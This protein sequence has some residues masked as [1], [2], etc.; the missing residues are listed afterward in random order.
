[1]ATVT[2]TDSRPWRQSHMAK[3]V[4]KIA[5]VFYELVAARVSRTDTW[6]AKCRSRFPWFVGIHAISDV[7]ARKM[8]LSPRYYGWWS[9][10]VFSANR[11]NAKHQFRS[12]P[13]VSVLSSAFARHTISS[14]RAFA[15]SKTYEIVW[16]SRGRSFSGHEGAGASFF[17]RHVRNAALHGIISPV[18]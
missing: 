9:P 15:V 10:F 7:C 3:V 13:S 8:A 14:F 2:H 4:S 5:I 12:L 16:R 6:R 11:G 17:A 18:V 1:M